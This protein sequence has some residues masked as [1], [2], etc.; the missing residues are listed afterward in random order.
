MD[1]IIKINEVLIYV[2][3]GVTV[4]LGIIGVI[5]LNAS[6][7]CSLSMPSIMCVSFLIMNL[8]LNSIEEGDEV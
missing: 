2:S 6:V 1:K 3:F 4:L 5:T 8:I 7:L